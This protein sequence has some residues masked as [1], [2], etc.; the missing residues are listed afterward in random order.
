MSDEILCM[1]GLRIIA[2]SEEGEVKT[3]VDGVDVRLRRG[4]VLGLIGESGAGKKKA[5]AAQTP[6]P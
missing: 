5:A 3:L 2:R 4:E 6:T 1:T